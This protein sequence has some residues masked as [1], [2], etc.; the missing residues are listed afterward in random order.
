MLF[1]YNII[2]KDFF[3][4]KVEILNEHEEE[5]GKQAIFKSN[6]L[7]EIRVLLFKL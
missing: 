3:F 5:L 2:F 6:K 7:L 1:F 4:M